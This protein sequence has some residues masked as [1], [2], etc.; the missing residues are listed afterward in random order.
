[1]C[2]NVCTFF[3]VFTLV[4]LAQATVPAMFVQLLLLCLIVHSNSKHLT[5]KLNHV[6]NKRE[7][8]TELT[9]IIRDHQNNCSK[10]TNFH[11]IGNNGM[12]SDIHLWS[13]SLCNSMQMGATLLPL[14]ERWIWND[15]EFC[16]EVDHKQPFGCYFDIRTECP[17]SIPVKYGA[18]SFLNDFH[19][20]PKYITDLESRQKFRAAAMEYLFLNLNP[21]IVTEAEKVIDTVFGEEGIPENMITLHM[22]LGDKVSEMK[23]VEDIEYYEAIAYM[24]KNHSIADPHIYVTTE[25]LDGLER[26]K[27][28]IKAKGQTWKVHCH[29]PSVFPS[30]EVLSPMVMAMRSQGSI[31]KHSL[32]ALLLALESPYYILTSGSNWSR[33]ID[34]LRKNVVDFDCNHCTHMIDLREAIYKLQN[35]R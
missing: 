25:S 23:L 19:L 15:V 2:G 26:L 22:R 4:Y 7:P 6:W 3:K 10:T 1:M 16:N 14:N 31:G 11:P 28:T 20:C 13:Q 24:V 8:N 18:V 17:H 29:T 12:G 27:Q 30:K 33:L 21:A 5:H 35:W 32:I 34:E 9:R